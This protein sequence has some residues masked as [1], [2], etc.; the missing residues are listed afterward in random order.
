MNGNVN[1]PVQILQ[2]L[3]GVWKCDAIFMQKIHL[4]NAECQMRLSSWGR[5]PPSSRQR[6]EA[7][8]FPSDRG[9]LGITYKVDNLLSIY[10]KS[11][12]KLK[13]MK[14]KYL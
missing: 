11:R 14:N 1:K 12:Y 13:G 5:Y 8:R 6:E 2:K 3:F 9:M 10:H 4:S 7:V